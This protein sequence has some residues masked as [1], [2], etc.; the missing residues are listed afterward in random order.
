MYRVVYGMHMSF[1][2]ILMGS[3]FQNFACIGLTNLLEQTKVVVRRI[4]SDLLWD[5]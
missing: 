2:N 4:R 3:Y 5:I 1:E